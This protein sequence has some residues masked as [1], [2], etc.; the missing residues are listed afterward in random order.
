MVTFVSVLLL[1]PLTVHSQGVRYP[2]TTW[3]NRFQE[4]WGAA[5]NNNANVLRPNN[6]QNRNGFQQPNYQN[7]F[8][9]TYQYNFSTAGTPNDIDLENIIRQQLAQ[10]GIKVDTLETVNGNSFQIGNGESGQVGNNGGFNNNVVANGYRNPNFEFM[11]PTGVR[12]TIPGKS[13]LPRQ[14]K[15]FTLLLSNSIILLYIFLFHI[16]LVNLGVD[17]KA[18]DTK[19]IWIGF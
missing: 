5:S 18:K 10:E 14:F 7:G 9:N 17:I 8:Q 4:V 12:I 3:N 11:N 19:T 15:Y 13:R 6:V 2:V 1:F 16:A